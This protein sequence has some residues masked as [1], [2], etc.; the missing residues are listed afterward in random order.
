MKK[1]NIERTLI[2]LREATDIMFQE[3]QDSCQEEARVAT[4]RAKSR[5]Q[6]S[7]IVEAMETANAT[8][9]CRPARKPLT[10]KRS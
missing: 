6:T 8:Q 10:P 5:K 1:V 2:L 4:K 9:Y 3:F 7:L